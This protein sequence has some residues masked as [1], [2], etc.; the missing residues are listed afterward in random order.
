MCYKWVLILT[1][2]LVT[3]LSKPPEVRADAAVI[4]IKAISLEIAQD[5]A[6]GAVDACRKE[7]YQVS[8]VV[9]DRSAVPQ[10]VLRDVYASRFAI[11]IAQRKANAVILAGVSTREF[12]AN[13][14]DLTPKLN[15]LD[16]LLILRGG[17]PVRVAGAM[18]G[19][20]G[21]SGAPGGDI[22]ERCAQSGLDKV[23]E[24]LEFADF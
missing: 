10:V 23:S 15:H 18:A 4:N 11:D 6:Q 5:I 7:G 17:L 20:V 1:A 13:R 21:V 14:A 9:V 2:A 22:D 16:D 19:A 8:V 12:A 24:R 3:T